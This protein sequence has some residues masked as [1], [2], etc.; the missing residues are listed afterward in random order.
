MSFDQWRQNTNTDANNLG[1]IA[2]LYTTIGGGQSTG[3]TA[4][5]SVIASLNDQNTRKLNLSGGVVSWLDITGNLNINTDKFNVVGATGNTTIAGDIA[6]NGG[7][8][9]SSAS[10]LNVGNTVVA[11]LNIGGSAD[12]NIGGSAKTVTAQGNLV[13]AS[14]KNLT[15]NSGTT[16]L[17]GACSIT[18]TNLNIGIT[19]SGTGI[20]SLSSGAV[21]SINNM[22]VGTTTRSSG[23]FTSLT[24]NAACTLTQNTS[25]TTSTTGTL[26]VTGGVGVSENINAAGSISA[27]SLSINGNMLRFLS[28]SLTTTAANQTLFSVG[29]ISAVR[30]GEITIRAQSATDY[31]VSKLTF[32]HNGVDAQLSEVSILALNA[33]VATYTITIDGSNNLIVQ[34]SPQ[35]TNTSYEISVIPLK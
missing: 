23:A 31:Q 8:I 9:T 33:L 11:T 15:V 17:N 16:S 7:D 21:G 29:S 30:A 32:L 27:S 28:T 2:T 10:T 4:P 24:A 26:V 13:V 19:S 6:V 12:V 34:V 20:T 22:A 35:T 14:S 1:D 25:S 5:S 18:A 3:I